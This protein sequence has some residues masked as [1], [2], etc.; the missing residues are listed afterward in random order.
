MRIVIALGGNALLKRNEPQD[1]ERLGQNISNA[2]EAIADIVTSHNV[3]ITH[4][5]GPQIG[6]LSMQNEAYD[7][8]PP[9]P[10][11]ILGAE[12]DGMIGYLIERELRARLPNTEVATL[13]T[14]V[15]VAIDDP[16]FAKPTKPIG[17]VYEEKTAGLLSRER[18]WQFVPDGNGFRRVVPS[19]KPQRV[20]EINSIRIL[21]EHGTLVICVGGG[22]I[23]V[24]E[25]AV[26]RGVE[27]VV[28]KD[29]SAA[30]LARMLGADFLLL[31]TDVDGVYANWGSKN[32]DPIRAASPQE[33][34]AMRFDPGSMAPKV[35]AACDF[36]TRTGGRAAI[37]ELAQA[38]AVLAGVSGTQIRADIE[39]HRR[40]TA[41]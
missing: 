26:P 10:L 19:P 2:A 4:G 20:V 28:D 8:V 27:A 12:S 15:T 34:D 30:L 39:G 1:A 3:V 21:Q 17:A 13:L 38:S 40:D 37:G 29:L 6:L 33:L 25:E 7:V 22:G 11:D 14:Q 24:T 35:A 16:A 23:P 5:N 9:Y 31:L 18:N 41:P 32:A 36:V